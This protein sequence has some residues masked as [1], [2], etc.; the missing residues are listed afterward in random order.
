MRA[1]IEPF[2]VCDDAKHYLIETL[3]I[4]G[5]A[6]KSKLREELEERLHFLKPYLL[7]SVNTAEMHDSGCV[8]YKKVAHNVVKESGLIAS[9]NKDSS[10]VS[11]SEG[12]HEEEDSG[13]SLD[14]V[15]AGLGITEDIV[16][17]VLP[18][19]EL[20]TTVTF[21]AICLELA[22]DR[23]P[24]QAGEAEKRV[25]LIFKA[26]SQEFE[27][28]DSDELLALITKFLNRAIGEYNAEG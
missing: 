28:Q 24:V 23:I 21:I 1:A 25:E 14:P 19:Y 6:N 10:H 11:G 12:P 2:G 7:L 9:S 8:E 20:F 16:E 5:T 15:K 4:V 27:G 22:A 17:D 13:E 18:A 3:E 26:A